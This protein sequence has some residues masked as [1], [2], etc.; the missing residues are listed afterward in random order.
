MPDPRGFTRFDSGHLLGGA[1]GACAFG[2][3][4]WKWINTAWRGGIPVTAEGYEP[5]ALR[6]EMQVRPMRPSE[7]S[8][9]YLVHGD[10]LRRVDINGGHKGRIYSHVQTKQSSDGPPEVTEELPEWFTKVPIADTVGRDIYRRVLWD[11]ARLFQI[12]MSGV[13]WVEPPEGGG[14][15]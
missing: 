9:V 11:A 1:A 6:L 5:P 14:A 12:G 10:H 4:E 7:P 2:E 8:V 3:I 13:P 15:R